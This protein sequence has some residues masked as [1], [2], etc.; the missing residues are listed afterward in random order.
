[1][2]INE[3]EYVFQLLDKMYGVFDLDDYECYWRDFLG[4]FDWVW[5]KVDVMFKILVKVGKV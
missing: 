1:M 2:S 3:L 5:N 4:Y